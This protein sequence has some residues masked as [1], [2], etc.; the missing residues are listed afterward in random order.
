MRPWTELR[1]RINGLG[2]ILA[3]DDGESGFA[4][5]V[6][7]DSDLLQIIASW[8]EGWDHVSVTKVSDDRPPSWKTMSWVKELFWRDDE[9]VMQLHPAKRDWINNH[10]GC[11][12]LWKPQ[13][14]AIPLPPPIMVGIKELNVR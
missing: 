12:H 10:P 14:A 3:H 13:H 2:L 6:Q 1:D 4:C 5:R 8:G 9:A 7:L 11:L